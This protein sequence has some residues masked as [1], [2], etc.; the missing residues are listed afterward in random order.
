MKG[1]GLAYVREASHAGSWYSKDRTTLGGQ[2]EGWLEAA[3]ADQ[4]AAAEAAAGGNGGG[5]APVRAII[6]PHAGYRY[7]GSAFDPA[8]IYMPLV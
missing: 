2:L 8:G 7:G 3:R 1:G 5:P 6:A 4:P